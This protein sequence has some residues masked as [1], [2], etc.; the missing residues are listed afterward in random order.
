AGSAAGGARAGSR[1]AAARRARD[2]GS[3]RAVLGERAPPLPGRAPAHRG[4]SRAGGLSLA[5]IRVR[6]VVR[7]R[8]RTAAVSRLLPA[9]GGDRE[10]HRTGRR[11]ADHA[12]AYRGGAAGRFPVPPRAVGP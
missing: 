2:G 3:D 4:R 9:R 6:P 8:S 7:A 12:L 11:R 5:W 1:L 10:G